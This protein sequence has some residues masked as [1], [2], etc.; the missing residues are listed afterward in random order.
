LQAALEARD[1]TQCGPVASPDGLYLVQVI[2]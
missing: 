1:R 2:Y